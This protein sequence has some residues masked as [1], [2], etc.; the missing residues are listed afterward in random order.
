MNDWQEAAFSQ[1]HV[2]NRSAKTGRSK[3]AEFDVQRTLGSY[4]VECAAARKLKPNAGVGMN[5]KLEIYCLDTA[6]HALYAELVIPEVLHAVVLLTA[7]RKTMKKTIARLE[8]QFVGTQEGEP[9]GQAANSEANRVDGPD[10]DGGAQVESHKRSAGRANYS[11][12]DNDEDAE[13]DDDG[14][15]EASDSEHKVS[16]RAHRIKKFEKNSFRVPKFW[17]AWQGHVL[18]D[19]KDMAV[20]G[21][22][23]SS[24]APPNIIQGDGYLVFK[25]NICDKFQGTLTCQELG[26]KNVKWTGRAIRKQ[27]PRDFEMEWRTVDHAKT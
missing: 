12:D 16:N 1:R 26:W 5:S 6:G 8:E 15:K 9:E 17:L 23:K 14:G 22:S 4:E 3:H 19:V 25:A 27:P 18:T 10:E 13:D 7:S 2:H 20:T 24:H 21:G 11:E